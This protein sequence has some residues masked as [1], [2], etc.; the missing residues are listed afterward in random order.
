MP[1]CP[2]SERVVMVRRGN[3]MVAVV[4]TQGSVVRP[5]YE[6]YMADVPVAPL[7]TL[8]FE[9]YCARIGKWLEDK[10]FGARYRKDLAGAVGICQMY[11]HIFRIIAREFRGEDLVREYLVKSDTAEAC[12]HQLPKDV[13]FARKARKLA[14]G[15]KTRAY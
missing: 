1:L 11:P 2:S 6:S 15:G 8:Y 12:A 7:R 5:A 14:A 9:R 4:G 10:P 13:S 3:K